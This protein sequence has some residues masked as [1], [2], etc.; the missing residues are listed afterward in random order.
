MLFR[1]FRI[2]GGL[3]VA[4]ANSTGPAGTV[5]GFYFPRSATLVGY[6]IAKIAI[7]ALSGWLIY[8]GFK[9]KPPASANDGG[10]HDLSK[11]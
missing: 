10:S 5:L 9:P 6:D 8:H 3:F 11:G 1:I 4:W 7:Y 2:I